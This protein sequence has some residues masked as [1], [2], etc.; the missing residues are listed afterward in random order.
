MIWHKNVFQKM[1]S[2]LSSPLLLGMRASVFSMVVKQVTPM[3][4]YGAKDAKSRAG[5]CTLRKVHFLMVKNS[6]VLHC[7]DSFSR[8]TF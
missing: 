1:F 2:E 7:C 5:I 6:S 8:W 4:F 3:F